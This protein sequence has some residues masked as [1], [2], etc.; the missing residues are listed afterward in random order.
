MRYL[1]ILFLFLAMGCKEAETYKRDKTD[2]A[3]LAGQYLLRG[4]GPAVP[5]RTERYILAAGGR[6]ERHTLNRAG[7]Y[8]EYHL[9]EIL[10]GRWHAM[11][12]SL[13]ITLET[14]QGSREETYLRTIIR[15]GGPDSTR[16]DTLW[17]NMENP[18][19][20]LLRLVRFR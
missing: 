7:R 17:T 12:S 6:A 15:G 10:R 20:T 9:D 5:N 18:G 13:V 4:E 16:V 14:P 19:Q 11:D 8:S 3:G 1:I 2:T